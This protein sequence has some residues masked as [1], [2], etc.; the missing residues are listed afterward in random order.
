MK[1]NSV[2]DVPACRFFPD[3]H[4]YVDV[5]L[6]LI[7]RAGE[8]ASKDIWHSTVQIISN[9]EDLHEY[10]ARKVRYLPVSCLKDMQC[11]PDI[12]LVG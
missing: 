6:T 12:H 1:Q 11:V 4:W 10:G 3:L 2:Y 8:F 7:D 9:N 5:M